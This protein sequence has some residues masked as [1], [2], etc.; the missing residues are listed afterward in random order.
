[1][2]LIKI[3]ADLEN[4]DWVKQTY[5]LPV[6]KELDRF[7]ERMGMTMAAFKKL[8]AYYLPKERLK[9]KAVIV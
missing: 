7:L 5:D 6:G 3:D 8:P 2:A 1:M 4:S 9:L